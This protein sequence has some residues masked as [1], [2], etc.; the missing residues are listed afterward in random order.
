MTPA[1]RA[2]QSAVDTWNRNHKLGTEVNYSEPASDGTV[3]NI[4]TKT[5]SLAWR[6]GDVA[7]VSVEGVVGGVKLEGVDVI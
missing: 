3:T 5:R 6:E 1:E 2:A 7:M 4:L